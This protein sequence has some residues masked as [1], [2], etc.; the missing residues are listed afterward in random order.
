MPPVAL[1]LKMGKDEQGRGAAKLVFLGHPCLY[2]LDD[3]D[4]E[5]AVEALGVGALAWYLERC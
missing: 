1:F 2:E 4:V 5:F 3:L